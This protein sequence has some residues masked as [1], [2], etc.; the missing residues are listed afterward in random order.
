MGRWHRSRLDHGGPERVTTA[1]PGSHG[2]SLSHTVMI[3]SGI[4]LP[5]GWSLSHTVM[6][7]SG[8]ILPDGWSLSQTVMIPSG[9]ILPGIIHCLAQ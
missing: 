2:W 7:P 1:P 8:I 9:I 5:D 3:P 6:I 4:I